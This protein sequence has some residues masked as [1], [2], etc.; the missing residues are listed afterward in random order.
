MQPQPRRH[1]R[2]TRRSVLAG[3]AAALLAGVTVAGSARPARAAG[4]TLVWY[5]WGPLAGYDV[6]AECNP[7]RWQ[8]PV[9]YQR[10][11]DHR[12]Q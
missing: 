10:C 11:G 6:A 9:R 2:L 3:G 12:G 8:P 4:F 7:G 5:E 1:A